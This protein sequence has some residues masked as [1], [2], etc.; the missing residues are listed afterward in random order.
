MTPK[1]KIGTKFRT[2]GKAPRLCTVVDIHS[3]Y[4]VNG[5]LVKIRYVAEHEFIG[6]TIRD[7]DVVETTIARG[8]VNPSEE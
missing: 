5:E 7:S 1:F 6:Q 2:M 3:T 4:N 8:L